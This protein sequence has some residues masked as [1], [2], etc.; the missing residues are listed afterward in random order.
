MIINYFLINYRYK[1]TISLCHTD[2]DDQLLR[3]KCGTAEATCNLLKIHQMRKM[4]TKSD[5]KT[6]S[7]PNCWRAPNRKS[8]F[9]KHLL[10][11][12]LLN[13]IQSV[14]PQCWGNSAVFQLVRF[15][16]YV[17]VY[18]L[19]TD[20][21]SVY[22]LAIAYHIRAFDIIHIVKHLTIFTLLVK[23]CFI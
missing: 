5:K 4:S 10:N 21:I 6:F 14:S 3:I 19:N 18:A 2:C 23:L 7:F 15:H 9:A 12:F 20:F 1:I 13:C 8:P 11:I 22:A 16:V 17:C